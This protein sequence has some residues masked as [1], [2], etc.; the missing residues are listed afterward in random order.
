MGSE[1]NDRTVQQLH[2][3]GM[4]PLSSRWPVGASLDLSPGQ[5]VLYLGKVTGGPRYGTRGVVRRRLA[6]RALVD[7][8]GWGTWHIPYY[9]LEGS[10]RAA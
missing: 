2:M 10:Q 3:P 5:E 4:P 8:G 7:M 6:R 1:P 9:F